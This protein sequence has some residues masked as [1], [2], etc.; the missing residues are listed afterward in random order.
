MGAGNS[1][2][3]RKVYECVLKISRP[4]VFQLLHHAQIN[5]TDSATVFIISSVFV[6]SLLSI[7]EVIKLKMF[8]TL[9]SFKPAIPDV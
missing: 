8:G 1:K 2:N 5:I 4:I 3:E 7:A 9:P 6:Q